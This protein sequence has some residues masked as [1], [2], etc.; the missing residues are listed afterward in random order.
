[1]IRHRQLAIFF[2][3]KQIKTALKDIFNGTEVIQAIGMAT[4][5]G[6]DQSLMTD[7]FAEG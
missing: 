4:L 5:T 1:M 2:Q 6:F 7:T 3:I